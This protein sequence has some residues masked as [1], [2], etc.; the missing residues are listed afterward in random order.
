[1]KIEPKKVP[2]K[3]FNDDRGAFIVLPE[4]ESPIDVDSFVSSQRNVSVSKKNV[5]R[6][7]HFQAHPH[8]QAKLITCISGEIMDIAVDIRMNEDTFRK[9]YEFILKPGDSV[10]IPKGF[11]HGFLTLQDA[12]M[13]YM[14]SDKYAPEYEET[15]RYDDKE[16]GIKWPTKSVILSEKDKKGKSLKKLK[17]EGRLSWY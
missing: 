3:I 7:L 15:L 12:V 6:G 4:F 14:V 1:M 8:A 17:D 2:T 16:I 11:A 10:F 5:L 9:C 13:H